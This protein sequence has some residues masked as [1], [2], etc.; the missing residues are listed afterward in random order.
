MP[1]RRRPPTGVFQSMVDTATFEGKLWAAPIWTNTQL[2]WYREDRIPKPPK[3]WDE[4]FKQAERARQGQPDPGPGQSLRGPRRLVQLDGRL[5]RDDDRRAQR[6][7]AGRARAGA[8]RHGPGDDGDA[9]RLALRRLLVLDL[10]RGQRPARL[11]VRQLG[12]HAQLPVRLPEREGERA[13]RLQEHR[14]RRATRGSIADIPSK[15]PLGGIILGVSAFSRHK[16][17][18]FDAIK[19]LRP[20]RQPARDRRRRGR[21]AGGREPLRL[22]RRSRRSTRGSPT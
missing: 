15:P 22:A 21:A 17:E 2:L 5:G 7:R 4:M 11:R 19:C 6:S 12:L 1:T 10:D 3:T 16:P 13:R 9:G 20:A 14:P 18:A 8:D